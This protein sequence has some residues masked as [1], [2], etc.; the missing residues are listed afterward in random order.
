MS[1]SPN[2]QKRPSRARHTAGVTGALVLSLLLLGATALAAPPPP[3][4]STPPT[5][6][7]AKAFEGDVALETTLTVET[8]RIADTGAIVVEIKNPAGWKFQ[9]LDLAG[10]DAGR[11][12]IQGIE[13]ET[14]GASAGTERFT[15]HFA[16]FHVGRFYFPPVRLE[17]LDADGARFFVMSDSLSVK[18]ASVLDDG[19]AGGLREADGAVSI[20]EPDQRPMQGAIV[21]LI[22]L[23]LI[24]LGVLVARKLKRRAPAPVVPGPARPPW[25]VALERLRALQDTIEAGEL[26]ERAA[27]FQLSEIIREYIGGR[28]AFDALEM[29][30]AEILDHLE[31]MTLPKGMDRTSFSLFLSELD[32]VKFARQQKSPEETREN[33]GLAEKVVVQTRPKA[34]VSSGD[35]GAE[36]AG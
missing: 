32:L 30:T 4:S 31:H 21:L 1:R 7:E 18:V 34:S 29:T 19:G 16:L 11:F 26:E 22:A 24:G 14:L 2:S 3:A 12:V 20:E 17:F 25:D 10:I 28:F 13:Q 15:I 23:S 9:P 35:T 8:L 36:N 5:P 27:Y 6:Q 33:V